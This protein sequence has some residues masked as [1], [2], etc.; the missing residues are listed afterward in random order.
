LRLGAVFAVAKWPHIAAAVMR[1]VMVVDPAGPAFLASQRDLR[2]TGKGRSFRLCHGFPD[3]GSREKADDSE[4]AHRRMKMAFG[5]PC[6]ED[7]PN[8]P[9]SST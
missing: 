9:G 7:L 4:H 6:A 2:G 8:R 5:K 1:F 3:A